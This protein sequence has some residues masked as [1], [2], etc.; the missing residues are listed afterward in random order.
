MRATT[1]DLIHLAE[2][3]ANAMTA[4]E[5]KN[6]WRGW[7][8]VA[9]QADITQALRWAAKLG[10]DQTLRPQIRNANAAIAAAVRAN[11]RRLT[12]LSTEDRERVFGYVAWLL[13]IAEENRRQK[14]RSN[15]GRRR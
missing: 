1:D 14:K 4:E 13:T 11:E 8:E 7:V 9:K 12:E 6:V 15:E 3:L 2:T 10:R 5:T